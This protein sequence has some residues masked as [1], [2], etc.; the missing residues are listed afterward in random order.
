M[1]NAPKLYIVQWTNTKNDVQV[2]AFATKALAI[3]YVNDEELTGNTPLGK[4]VFIY[5]IGTS[6]AIKEYKGLWD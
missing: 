3:A 5:K 4:G 6:A 1:P 2:A